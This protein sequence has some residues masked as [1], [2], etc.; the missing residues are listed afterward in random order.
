MNL[1]N[2]LERM[3][4]QFTFSLLNLDRRLTDYVHIRILRTHKRFE[5]RKIASPSNSTKLAILAF[6]PRSYLLSS[7]LRLVDALIDS[8]FQIIVVVNEGSDD[9]TKWMLELNQREITI[10]SRP[11]VGQDFGAYQA[12]IAYMRKNLTFSNIESL[13]LANDSLYYFPTSTEFIQ[14]LV[15]DEGEWVSMFVNFDKGMHAQ[16]FFQMFNRSIILNSRFSNFWSNYYPTSFRHKVIS[17]GELRLSKILRDSGFNPKSFVTS[18]SI[19]KSPKFVD[20]WVEEKYA[21]WHGY[22]FLEQEKTI[23]TKEVNDERLDRIFSEV[24]VSLHAGVL[25]TRILGAPLKLEILSVGFATIH[26]L[27]R[28]AELAGLMKSESRDFETLMLL[29]G[30]PASKAGIKKLWNRHGFS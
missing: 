26:G 27:K 10:I 15:A 25:C 30:S 14:N 20:Y 17:T 22:N 21:M 8:G 28:L 19:L 13:I 23:E 11:N 7:N 2:Y 16:S 24:N 18:E 3:F 12:G 9:L 29:K 1:K 6:Y 5:V 4:A